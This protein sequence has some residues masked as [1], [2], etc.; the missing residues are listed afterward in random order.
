MAYAISNTMRCLLLLIHL[1]LSG[2]LL[3]NEGR[4]QSGSELSSVQVTNLATLGKLWGFLKYYHP[5]VANGAMDWDSALLAKMPLFLEA[6]TIKDI[7]NLISG[8]LNELGP[9]DS[10]RQCDNNLSGKLTYN[11]DTQWM[12][13]AGFSPGVL[14]R[15]QFM[16]KNRYHGTPHYYSA[17]PSW[18]IKILNEK[19][20]NTPFYQ[21]PP[22]AWRLLTLFRY[23][24][25]VNY[26][27]PYKY[28]TSKKWDSIL[29]RYIPLFYQAEDTL[30]YHLNIMKMI[31]AL[32]DGHGALTWSNTLVKHFGEYHYVSFQCFIVENK[33][34]VTKIYNRA[35][36][37]A[38]GIELYDIIDSIDGESVA[39]RMRK[40]TPYAYSASNADGAMAAICASFLFSGN[41]SSCTIVKTGAEG[42]KRQLILRY[43]TSSAFF[44]ESKQRSWKI[45]PG[46]IGYVNMEYLQAAEVEAIMD[47]LAN[48][49]GIIFDLRD[50]P[51]NTWRSIA[52][53]L[54]PVKFKMSRQTYPD[55]AYPGVFKYFPEQWVGK[56]NPTPYQGKVVL[57]VSAYSK[58]HAEYSAMGLQAATKTITIGSTTAGANGDF[59]DWIN[60]P[61]GFRTRFSGLGIYY[62]D[63]TIA[64]KKGVKIDIVCRPSLK[65]AL[66]RKDE[67]IEMAIHV[68]E[69]GK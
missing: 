45:F 16:R 47:S 4:N 67:Y 39:Q 5:A 31:A 46:N 37:Q 3:S 36:C 20:Y 32:E 65:G 38:Q 50:Y 19:S 55:L 10:C 33:A 49:T 59:T 69:R 35:I 60:L 43:Q 12:S 41:D 29:T 21:Y 13:K 66:V 1:L 40:Y 63:E 42:R 26:F 54:S 14:T 58:S 27:S 30:G 9:V 25:I 23:W 53:R 56:N 22:P 24:N 61:G 7:N 18:Q 57:L 62:P 28:L 11:L 15:L 44:D 8:W 68:I 64:Q 52:G 48:T 34:V 6:R 17:G 51:A 2:I